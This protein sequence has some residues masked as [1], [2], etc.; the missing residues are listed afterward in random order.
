MFS[1]SF[2]AKRASISSFRSLTRVSNALPNGK[3]PRSSSILI[4]MS[5]EG[6]LKAAIEELL[7]LRNIGCPIGFRESEGKGTMS[8]RESS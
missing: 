6:N 5:P 4:D 8:Q 1:L 3:P 7:V 2:T